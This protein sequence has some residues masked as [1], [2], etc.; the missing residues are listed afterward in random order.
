M[1]KEEVEITEDQSSAASFQRIF[2][3]K[4]SSFP[5]AANMSY[6]PVSS[7]T[8]LFSCINN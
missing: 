1:I 4:V 3:T 6:G 8:I 2:G 5:N 7:P